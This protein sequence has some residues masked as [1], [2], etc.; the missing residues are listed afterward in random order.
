MVQVIIERVQFDLLSTYQPTPI[1]LARVKEIESDLQGYV[2][3]IEEG[4]HVGETIDTFLYNLTGLEV[5]HVDYT[6]A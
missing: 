4:E 3:D 6:L 1:G 2:I 5:C